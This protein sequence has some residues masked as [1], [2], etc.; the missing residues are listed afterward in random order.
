MSVVF[1]F[2]EVRV[3]A[4]LCSFRST[5]S[6]GNTRL[7][8]SS[9]VPT[10]PI[11][12]T[13]TV[14]HLWAHPRTNL[15]LK[16][17]VPLSAVVS[18]GR[19]CH[20]KTTRTP[21]AHLLNSETTTWEAKPTSRKR[22]LWNGNGFWCSSGR[23]SWGG[24]FALGRAFAWWLCSGGLLR[25]QGAFKRSDTYQTSTEVAGLTSPRWL[26]ECGLPRKETWTCAIASHFCRWGGTGIGFWYSEGLSLT[27]TGLWCFCKRHYR[28]FVSFLGCH[29]S[30]KMRGAKQKLGPGIFGKQCHS[31]LDVGFWP[32]T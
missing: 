14:V 9:I 20:S 8:C 5:S 25:C 7:L 23:Q 3:L 21:L 19:P 28:T 18:H 11:L 27:L 6:L 26:T 2:A 29:W 32:R 16:R 4:W 22:V 12:P 17:A 10:Q 31:T 15:K 30:L 24:Q 13:T 1:E